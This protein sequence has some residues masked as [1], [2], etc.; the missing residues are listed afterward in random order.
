MR[1]A[2]R[3]R[4]ADFLPMALATLFW[5]WPTVFI[6]YIKRESGDAF[7][8]DALNVYRYAAGSFCAL[9]IVALLRPGDLLTVLRR[10]L[11]PLLLAAILAAFQIVWVRGVYHL[12]AAYSVLVGR[13]TVIFALLLSYAVFADERRVIRSGRFLLSAALAMAAVAGIVVLDPGFSVGAGAASQGS[14]P[15]LL[16]GTAILLVSAVIWAGYAVAIRG[17]ARSLP[18]MATFAVTAVLATLM[19]VP[20][21]LID[22]HMGYIWSPECSWRVIGAVV[23]SGALCVGSTQVLY[24]V[25]L[26]RIG[27]ARTTLVSLA[28]PFLTGVS[29]WLVLGGGERLTLWQ[30]LLGGALVAGLACMV[31]QP[32]ASEPAAGR[33]PGEAP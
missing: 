19:M 29:A 23:F 28:T 15:G 2:S 31:W 1:L 14:G 27:V 25:S 7:T 11:V 32:A 22:G 10:P 17:L 8:A 26:R 33:R 20:A 16:G 13:S 6:R 30:W 9:G 3:P 5:A 18:S 4:S 21:G 12:N 24:Y